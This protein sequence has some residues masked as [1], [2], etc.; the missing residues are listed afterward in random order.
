[1]NV[2]IEGSTWRSAVRRR[3]RRRRG[4]TGCSVLD[5]DDV[6]ATADD[7]DDAAS[8]LI[9]AVHVRFSHERATFV[10]FVLSLVRG[11]AAVV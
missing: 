2:A 4:H 7:D 11:G 6:A 1:M 8:A 10:P 5:A 3:R 9:A